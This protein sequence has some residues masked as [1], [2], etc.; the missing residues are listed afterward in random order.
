MSGG[1]PAG[2]AEQVPERGPRPGIL[3]EACIAS[4]ADARAAMAGGAHR[5]ELN[6]DLDRDGLT[7]GRE[8]LE[9]V[10][11][12]TDLPVIVMIRPHDDG[13]VYS[14]TEIDAMLEAAQTSLA[15]GAAGIAVGPLTETGAVGPSLRGF[16]AASGGR[17]VVFHRAFD[18]VRHPEQ[19]LDT[20]ISM[21]VTRVLTSGQAT[22]AEEGIPLLADL[23][24]QAEGRIEILP[25]AGVRPDSAGAI[26]RGT[27]CM[28]LH[29]SFRDPIRPDRGTD[30]ATV[31]R[32]RR[33]ANA[34][35]NRDPGART[36]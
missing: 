16:V 6:R 15:A 20:L 5:L 23:V 17:D 22:T 34:A 28:Q 19:A 21:G 36:E 18:R 30:A 4:V 29:G 33:Q 12:V 11:S 10:L 26:V 9:A 7:P 25:G 8:L 2:R 27:G 3:I 14:E 13:F 32:V 1:T 31:A 24:R 35:L